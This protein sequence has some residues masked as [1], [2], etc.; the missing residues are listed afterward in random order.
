VRLSSRSR[1]VDLF[2]FACSS[3]FRHNN[4][5][6]VVAFNTAEKWCSDVS[7]DVSREVLN[8]V[9]SQGL[10]LPPP[11]RSFVNFMFRLPRNRTS[12]KRQDLSHPSAKS[13]RGIRSA[14]FE[15]QD[16]P[17]QI[18][19]NAPAFRNLLFDQFAPRS[20]RRATPTPLHPMQEGY[21]KN[22]QHDQRHP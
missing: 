5:K 9:A 15:C 3:K 20:A 7:E 22:C 8:G 21:P 12:R 10:V 4:S 11:P 6:R 18:L 16:D 17:L 1:H 19:I 14:F 2:L 13:G